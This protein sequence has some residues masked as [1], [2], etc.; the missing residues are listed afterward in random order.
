M[1]NAFNFDFTTS[2]FPGKKNMTGLIKKN[3]VFILNV[4]ITN[5]KC[6]K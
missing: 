3:P 5:G 4:S 2:A 6:E 1:S